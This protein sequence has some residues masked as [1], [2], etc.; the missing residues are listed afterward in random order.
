MA[1]VFITIMLLSFSLLGRMTNA[2]LFAK[3]LKSQQTRTL[4]WIPLDYATGCSVL[5]ILS[6]I[7]LA[8]GKY[9]PQ[10]TLG[11][12]LLLIFTEITVLIYK[13][14]TEYLG[15]SY[16]YMLAIIFLGLATTLISVH[17]PGFWDDTSYHLIVS[18][19]LARNGDLTPNLF[20]RYPFSPF[21]VDILFSLCFFA[22]DFNPVTS[23]YYCQALANA[24][25]FFIILLLAASIHQFTRSL[26]CLLIGLTLFVALRKTSITVHTGYAYVDYATAL[27]TFSS[28]Y[29][30]MVIRHHRHLFLYIF[31]GMLLGI[32]AG[33]KYQAAAICAIIAAGAIIYLLT[34]RMIKQTVCLVLSC[35]VF[36]SFWY[37]RNYIQDGN[38]VDP[39]FI[40]IFGSKVWDAEDFASNAT[41]I[42]F[43]RPRGIDAVMHNFLWPLVF[44]WLLV[45][46]RWT[47]LVFRYR[48]NIIPNIKLSDYISLGLTV[49]SL[50]WIEMFP[51]P[52]Y[53]VPA[54]SILI[55]YTVVIGNRYFR[56]VSPLI[57]IPFLILAV[58]CRLT[59]PVKDHWKNSE[60]Q[61]E[62]FITASKISQ[63]SDMLLTID[64]EERNKYF[65][66]GVTVGDLY[67]NARFSNFYQVGTQNL[68]APG[69]FLE[70]MRLYKTRRA[71]VSSR[72]LDKN[73]INEYRKFFHIIKAYPGSN[74]GY[75][76]EP[77][78]PV[79]ICKWLPPHSQWM[80]SNEINGK[81]LLK[82]GSSLQLS[83]SGRGINTTGCSGKKTSGL[84]NLTIKIIELS[85]WNDQ[86]EIMTVKDDLDKVWLEIPLK[87]IPV[88]YDDEGHRIRTVQLNEIPKFELQNFRYLSI[89]TS[90]SD[91]KNEGYLNTEALY[92]EPVSIDMENQKEKD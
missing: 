12:L 65:Y 80:E 34:R 25:L 77:L 29:Y 57:I 26:S 66:D 3:I 23:V 7:L 79:I 1:I 50:A 74:G 31:L 21:N 62:L 6:Q 55:L 81:P 52:R 73:R 2:L 78:S 56:K 32:T 18:R 13:E 15:I 27:F 35:I 63:P 41:D 17:N 61:R 48:R 47:Y 20:L 11:G 42:R 24:P 19:D 89:E 90:G 39:F 43:D 86:S 10:L 84:F 4:Q 30:L 22:T 8:L 49:Y 60:K 5:I 58:V 88:S 40:D 64:V 87:E 72:S 71:I 83:L 44:I 28:L 53:L 82:N 69:D 68:I 92:I 70:K 67:G 46:G 37:V 59:E 38:P 91:E 75:L 51:V 36:G 33:C 14:K 16:Q 9:T 54:I 85:N 45:V 76:I